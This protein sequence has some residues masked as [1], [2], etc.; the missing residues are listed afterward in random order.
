KA[1]GGK[2]GMRDHEIAH[3]L[4][5]SRV[6]HGEDLIASK[7]AGGQQHAVGGDPLQDGPSLGQ[8]RAALI[9]HRHRLDPDALRP[10]LPLKPAPH[11]VADA[12]AP[13]DLHRRA[14]HHPHPPQTSS[15]TVTISSSLAF[16]SSI[17]SR[18]PSSVEENPHCPDRQSWSPSTNCEASSMRR[19]SR[20]L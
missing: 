3:T 6:D 7:V 10:Q 12:G 20:S 11:R 13:A 17:V 2:L 14:L 15:A 8:H 9:N 18:L 4:L 5:V 16:S 19:L 1:L